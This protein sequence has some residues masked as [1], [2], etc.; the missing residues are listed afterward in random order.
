MQHCLRRSA[1]YSLSVGVRLADL[2][3]AGWRLPSQR[4]G[5]CCWWHVVSLLHSSLSAQIW[6]WTVPS[7][8]ALQSPALYLAMSGTTSGNCFWLP[9]HCE[10]ILSYCA[11]AQLTCLLLDLPKLARSAN[12][13]PPCPVSGCKR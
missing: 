3:Y 13:W 11:A 4:F 6:P 7:Y 9:W 12:A 10:V 1:D 8:A 2:R 5:S